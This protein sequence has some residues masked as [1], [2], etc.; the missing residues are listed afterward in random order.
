MKHVKMTHSG[1]GPLHTYYYL[2]WMYDQ[3]RH[4]DYGTS[5]GMWYTIANAYVQCWARERSSGRKRKE[6]IKKIIH[7]WVEG[8][9]RWGIEYNSTHEWYRGCKPCD[10]IHLPGYGTEVYHIRE[11]IKQWN[12]FAKPSRR[13]HVDFD[14]NYKGI[15][16]DKCLQILKMLNVK[17]K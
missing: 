6:Y 12:K 9:I 13:I 11:I 3:M 14:N 1:R 2:E 8:N 16:Y 17:R 5:Y 4:G 7:V 10:F 15:T